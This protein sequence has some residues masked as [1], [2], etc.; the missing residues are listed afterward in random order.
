MSPVPYTFANDF[1][2]IPLSE[3]DTNFANC[4]AFADTAGLVTENA[5]PA[6]TSVGVMTNLSV[7]GNIVGNVIGNINPTSVTASGNITGGNI[8][9]TGLINAAGNLEINQITANGDIGSGGNINVFG[10]VSC[11]NVI[12]IGTINAVQPIATTSNIFG[13]NISST[14]TLK[15]NLVVNPVVYGNITANATTY[16]LST[17]NSLNILI[18][19]NTGYTVT[20]NMPTIQQEGQ[21]C[22]F[23]VHGNTMTLVKGTGNV[24]PTF[25]GSA[26]VGTSFRYVYST[27]NSIWYKI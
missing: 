18:A 20:L 2:N 16:S 11:G 4:K 25:A 27:S 10:N 6:I 1:G 13:N 5:Q 12:T 26:T 21:I 19:N 7:A 14:N 23:A 9:S 24:S 15:G 3:L 8:I 17:N 22:N